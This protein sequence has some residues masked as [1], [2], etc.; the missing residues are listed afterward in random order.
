[1]KTEDNDTMVLTV[2]VRANKHLIK[3]AVKKLRH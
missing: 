3:K 2:D 1:M